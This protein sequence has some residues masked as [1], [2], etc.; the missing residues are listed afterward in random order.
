MQLCSFSCLDTEL[1]RR[2]LVTNGEKERKKVHLVQG[3]DEKIR[4][5]TKTHILQASK[6]DEL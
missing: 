1:R 6:I 4:K 2:N 5:I 3:A